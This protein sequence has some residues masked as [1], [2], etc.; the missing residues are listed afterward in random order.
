MVYVNLFLIR[1]TG[2]N[3]LPKVSCKEIAFSIICMH[4]YCKYI[5]ICFIRT[6]QNTV[7]TKL[8]ELS[9]KGCHQCLIRLVDPNTEGNTNLTDY[10]KEIRDENSTVNE[11]NGTQLDVNSQDVFQLLQRLYNIEESVLEKVDA[12]LG[13]TYFSDDYSKKS[14]A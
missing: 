9:D 3:S 11:E 2:C 1:C 14:L 5:S 8:K 6:F 7:E 12:T 13:T 10:P 4:I